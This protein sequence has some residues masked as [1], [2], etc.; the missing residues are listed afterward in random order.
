MIAEISMPCSS[1]HFLNFSYIL[2][3]MII[4]F[5]RSSLEMAF[6]HTPFRYLMQDGVMQTHDEE[7]RRVFKHSSVKVLL[8]PR[9]AGKRH[10]W[11]KQKV[12]WK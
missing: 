11:A 8:C 9:I 2:H 5:Y 12:G 4:I 10:S 3:A 1:K 6:K 7:T